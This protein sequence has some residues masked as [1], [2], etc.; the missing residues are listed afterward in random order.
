MKPLYAIAIGGLM[1]VLQT[2]D[3]RY[4]L[5]A[6][7][8]GWVLIL[9]AVRS[10]VDEPP[11]RFNSALF[12]T[13]LL[14]LALDSVFWFPGPRA[15]LED[16]EDA[17][18]WAVGVPTFVCFGLICHRLSMAALARGERLPAGCFQWTGVAMAL[19]AIGPVL[20]YGAGWT[21]LDSTV[22]TIVI[23]AQLA[24]IVLTFVFAPR[25]WAAG[26][27]R[28]GRDAEDVEPEDSDPA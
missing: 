26:I 25:A 12:G 16:A 15:W 7:P 10:L 6:N 2:K 14:A 21:E 18:A 5:Y 9:M 11:Y 24:L 1:I 3:L 20:V 27:Q 4:D 22:G 13:G 23:L 19:A 28:P 17:L 8:L